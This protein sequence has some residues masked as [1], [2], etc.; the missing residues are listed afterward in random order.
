MPSGGTFDVDRLEEERGKIN[1]LL[2]SP[3]IWEDKDRITELR[4]RLSK[5]ENNL[6]LVKRLS[7]EIEDVKAGFLLLEEEEDEGLIDEVLRKVERI[8]YE[9]ERENLKRVMIDKYDEGP[10]LMTIKPGA[11]GVESQDWAYMLFRMFIR[12]L[13]REGFDFRV[14]YYQPA[15]EVGIKEAEILVKSEYSYGYLISE[16]GVHRLIRLSPFD[17]NHKR[18]TSFAGVSVIPYFDRDID[19]EIEPDELKIDTFRSSGPG[20]QHVNVTDSAVRITHLP[21]GI[22][23]TCQDERS[24]HRNKEIALNILKSRLY[25][26]KMDEIDNQIEKVRDKSNVNFGSQ[27]RSYILH[28]Y[29]LVKD[30]RTGLEITDTGDVLD[31]NIKPFIEAY[32]KAKVMDKL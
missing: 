32:L 27:I 21:T 6:S 10:A 1:T 30:H 26:M 17:A 23:V 19:I 25:Q 20:G 3:D 18:H 16:S 15:E 14:T 8:T 7:I 11:G 31:G 2:T 12:F 5:I 28:P 29:R 24:Q 9:I 13:E 22:V 4:K